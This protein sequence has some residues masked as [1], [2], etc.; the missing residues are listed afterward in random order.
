[1]RRCCLTA[2]CNLVVHPFGVTT[3]V[4]CS[5]RLVGAQCPTS[6]GECHVTTTAH[7]PPRDT[8]ARTA[9]EVAFHQLRV[10]G[11]G[12]LAAA[13]VVDALDAPLI[14]WRAF[15]GRVIEGL[16]PLDRPSAGLVAVVS[17]LLSTS[18]R[19]SPVSAV[20]RR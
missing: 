20:R 7:R 18:D 16:D 15:R 5:E 11:L 19:F 9:E 3:T 14:R 13:I 1:L 4:R 12:L 8:G 17:D 6:C 2:S 10:L